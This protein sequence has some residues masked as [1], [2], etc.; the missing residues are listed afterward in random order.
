MALVRLYIVTKD[1]KHLR[2]ARYFIDQR[3]QSPLYFEEET[4]RNGNTFYWEDSYVRYQY[5]QAGKPV[6]EQHTAEGHAVRAAYLYSGIADVA[7][8]TGDEELLA[9]CKALFADITQKQ[10]YLTGAVGQSAY[11]E[12]F[13]YD[14][15]LPNDTVYGETC[16][17]IGL[18]FFARRMTSIEPRAEY[19]DVIERTLFNGIISGMALDGESFFYVNP[20]E[21]LPEASLKDRRMRHVKIERQKWFGCACCPPNLA[22]IIASL[23]TYIYSFNNDCIYTHLYAGSNANFFIKGKPVL[24]KTETGYPWDGRVD[25]GFTLEGGP[26]QFCYGFRIPSWCGSFQVEL[27]GKRIDAA[28]KDGYALIRREWQNNDKLTIVFDMPVTV[29]E[30]NPKVRQDAGKIAVTRGPV[31]YCLEEADNGKEL[32]RLRLGE[33]ADF[34]AKYEPDLLG[35]LTVISC[36]GKEQPVWD[37]D[38]LYRPAATA[39]CRDKPL[40]FIPYYA[41]ANRGPGEMTVW[42]DK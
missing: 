35:G 21:V 11:G 26:A 33:Q 37:R 22:R 9:V 5:Y 14:Y 20:L 2:L 40:R 29:V 17:A 6:R 38:E 39:R 32:M 13:S 34:T 4:R 36:T 42:I 41:W 24:V 31:V 23:G 1:E 27:N 10:M 8:L 16:A 25:T 12:A 3:G 7:R 15:D 30:A 28:I 18:A 19:A